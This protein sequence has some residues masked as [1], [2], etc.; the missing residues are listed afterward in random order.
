MQH[1]I[2]LAQLEM[3]RRSECRLHTGQCSTCCPLYM[4]IQYSPG[5]VQLL[6]RHVRPSDGGEYKCVMCGSLTHFITL[7]KK[8]NAHSLTH[9]MISPI[10]LNTLKQS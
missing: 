5:S 1:F 7:L 3:P 6:H 9:D 4:Y 10:Y 8:I 2:C